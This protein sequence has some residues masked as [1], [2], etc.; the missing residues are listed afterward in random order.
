MSNEKKKIVVVGASRG[1]GRAVALKLAERARVVA[2]ARDARALETLAAEHAD[3]TVE[4]GEATDPTF[5]GRV[6][7]QHEPDALVLVAGAQPLMQPI[8][9]YDWESFERPF[10]TDTK[11]TF[12]W[13]RDALRLP[14]KPGG[15]IVVFSS[16]AAIGGSFLSGG[17]ASAKQAQRFLCNYARQEATERDLGLTVQCLLPQLNPNTRL[18]AAGIAAYARRA[19]ESVDG[20]VKKRFG[21]ALTPDVAAAEVARAL[22]G[23]LDDHAELML[24]GKGAS[25]LAA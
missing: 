17:Y 11:L 4:P 8:S 3:I 18:G 20:F 6:L 9:Q 14:M 15:R 1:L 22:A 2:I 24:T 23:E 13:L 5:S 10:Q 19:G 21:V 25:P 7:A 12:H 16:G